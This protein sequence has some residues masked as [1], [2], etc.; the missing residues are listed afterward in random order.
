MLISICRSIDDDVVLRWGG[1]ML[2]DDIAGIGF[3]LKDAFAEG[4]FDMFL[5]GA[6]QGAGTIFRVIT[7]VGEERFHGLG[8]LDVVTL[9]LDAR[10]D[11][12]EFD[13][14]NLADVIVRQLSEGDDVVNTVQELG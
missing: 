9:F 14:H 5:N 12:L 13:V 1:I 8:D 2:F 6:A 11:R 4:I 10:Q 3:V 7:S